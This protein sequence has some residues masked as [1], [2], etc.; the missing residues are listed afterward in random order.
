MSFFKDQ[1]KVSEKHVSAIGY[2]RQPVEVKLK[3]KTNTI[4]KIK[5]IKFLN[6]IIE[7]KIFILFLTFNKIISGIRK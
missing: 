3:N 2:K 4:G 1:S 5:K 7:F 6:L